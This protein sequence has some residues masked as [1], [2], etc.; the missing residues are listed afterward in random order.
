MQPQLWHSICRNRGLIDICE[1]C[2]DG[3]C[4]NFKLIY[5]N[6]NRSISIYLITVYTIY[7][8]IFQHIIFYYIC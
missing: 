4:V 8:N 3:R 1:C 6:G 5:L 2:F 7:T